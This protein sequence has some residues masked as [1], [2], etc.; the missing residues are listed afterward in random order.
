MRGKWVWYV[1]EKGE[2]TKCYDSEEE[3][4]ERKRTILIFNP[5][6]IVKVQGILE[7]YRY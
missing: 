2:K 7:E 5:K 3:A 4:L 6:A 1:F